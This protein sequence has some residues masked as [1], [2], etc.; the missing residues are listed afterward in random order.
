MNTYLSKDKLEE[1]KLELED[2]QKVQ[3]RAIASKIS[4][5]L[6]LGDLSENF[7]YHEAKE[8]A[9]QNEARI[10]QI[11]EMIRSAKIVGNTKGD[12]IEIGST[13]VAVCNNVNKTFEIVGSSESSPMEGKISNESPLG[14][15][16]LGHK[17]NDD[18][19]VELPSG[20][21][22]YKITEIK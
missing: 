15:A 10:L 8:Q 12:T 16:F 22:C 9:A 3:R 6:E 4:S 1:L 5:A 18:I 19:E 17:V 2:R 11:M 7:E 20:S 14:Q 13:F 21:I